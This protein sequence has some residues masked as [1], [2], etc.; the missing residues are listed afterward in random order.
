MGA[1]RVWF[2]MILSP[3]ANA[4]D[5]PHVTFYH[6]GMTFSWSVSD[7]N[8]YV[9]ERLET[10]IRLR[11]VSV[12]GE[13]SGFKA[14]PSGHW[15][16]TLKDAQAQLSCVMWRSRAERSRFRPREGEAVSALGRVTLYEA[17]G[18]YQFEVASLQP[19][20]A[21]AL[22]QQF[23]LLKAQLE[24]EGLFDPAR[25][26]PLPRLP[27][28]IGLVTSAAGAALHDMLTILRRR[29]PLAEVVLAPAAVQGPEAPEQLVA[30]LRR[31]A[32]LPAATRPQVVIAGRGGGALEDLWAFNTAEV[33]RQLAAMPMPTV[34][35]VGH[36]TDTTLADWAADV[37]APTPSA[38]AELVSA[39]TR[40]DLRYALDDFSARLHT[41]LTA[42]LADR[43][44]HLTGLT[45]RL[46]LLAPQ[47]HL[48][49]QRAHLSALTQHLHTAIHHR[50]ALHRAHVHAQT[51]RLH[52][53][54]PLAVLQRGYALITRAD[55]S[56][57]TAAAQTTPGE[58]VTIQWH[59]AS[60]PAHLD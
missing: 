27:R 6:V 49:Q 13:V 41:A 12:Q 39:L 9:R 11:E 32:A 47:A 5:S 3:C 43:A 59:D 8:R 25:K 20:G 57:L 50:L 4:I 18:Q 21:G 35:A 10:D 34:S 22:Y 7:L 53:V 58:P 40:D 26:R 23:L 60:R 31:L 44:Q 45:T 46:R 28:R 17:R 51:Q 29:A 33:V 56:P 38:A 30:A 55:G 48:S 1:Q 19:A 24:A 15:Y 37:R 16:F 54:G 36:E 52:A 2:T 42:D 14:Y